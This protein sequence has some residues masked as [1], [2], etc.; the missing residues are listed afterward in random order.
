MRIIYTQSVKS[1]LYKIKE[2]ITRDSREIA[3]R[4]LKNIKSKIEL[5]GKYPYIGKVNTTANNPSIRDFVIL[6]YKVIYKVNE[7]S[8]TLLAIY[9][10]IDFD[11]SSLEEIG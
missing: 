3:L 4:H 5:I 6:G 9:K 11:E 1:Q 10:Y 8:I 2:Y 7:K